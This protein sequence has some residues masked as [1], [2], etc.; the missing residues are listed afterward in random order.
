MIGIQKRQ[1]HPDFS[2]NTHDANPL[3]SASWT[4]IQPC[5]TQCPSNAKTMPI[6]P[7]QT[8]PNSKNERTQNKPPE[9]KRKKKTAH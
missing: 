2:N 7:N 9:R 6:T 3:T 5:D 4:D 1:T 8:S